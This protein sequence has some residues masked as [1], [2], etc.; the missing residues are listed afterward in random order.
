MEN[1]KFPRY[2]SSISLPGHQND[3]EK[4]IVIFEVQAFNV[5]SKGP[6]NLLRRKNAT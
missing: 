5:K 3:E 1:E 6:C 2:H 4:F